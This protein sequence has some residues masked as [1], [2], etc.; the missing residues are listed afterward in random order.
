MIVGA[1]TPTNSR[2]AATEKKEEASEE[3]MYRES[4]RI[5]TKL[6][7]CRDLAFQ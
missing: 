7:K 6:I 3:C 2:Y 4:N 5:R 1:G